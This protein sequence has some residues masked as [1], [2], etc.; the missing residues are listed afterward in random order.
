ML[1]GEVVVKKLARVRDAAIV[2]EDHGI[3]TMWVS[4]DLEGGSAQAFGGWPLDSAL[5]GTPYRGSI[6]GTAYIRA[7]LDLFCASK[8]D[9]IKE[10]PVYALYENHDQDDV[11]VGLESIA[12]QGRSRK[13]L[14]KDLAETVHMLER[15]L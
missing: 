3:L 15:Q 6:F 1:F 14:P 5:R 10:K 4:L 13:F 8:L 12:F 11:I 2:V 9:E 7:V